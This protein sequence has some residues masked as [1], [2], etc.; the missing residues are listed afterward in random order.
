MYRNSA[1]SS[2]NS[3]FGRFV[4]FKAQFVVKRTTNSIFFV[5]KEVQTGK[6]FTILRFLKS[7]GDHKR[8]QPVKKDRILAIA[9][10]LSNINRDSASYIHELLSYYVEDCSFNLVFES[11]P[12]IKLEK[13]VEDQVFKLYSS[14]E[15]LKF[16]V[17]EIIW[18][19]RALHANQIGH[20]DLVI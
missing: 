18:G 15:D 20:R 16:Y 10:R 17:I 19:L 11:L 2:L 14:S 9:N 12:A 3:R 13:L 4:D 1:S 5:V 7:P 8:L 6:R